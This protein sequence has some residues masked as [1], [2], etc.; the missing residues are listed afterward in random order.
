MTCRAYAAFL[1]AQSLALHPLRAGGTSERRSRDALGVRVSMVAV[2]RHAG[3]RRGRPGAAGL[4]LV[5]PGA[6][7]FFGI[8]GFD[9]VFAVCFGGARPGGCRMRDQPRAQLPVGAG[10]PGR[11][12]QDPRRGDGGRGRRA[13][14]GTRDD[15][16]LR[17]ATSPR[18]GRGQGRQHAAGS[19]RAPAAPGATCGLQPGRVK[20]RL[21]AS[22]WWALP[23]AGGRAVAV[24]DFGAVGAAGGGGAVGVEGDGPAPLVNGDV[25]MEEAVKRTSVH[26]GLAAVG[27]VGHMVDFAG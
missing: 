16:R 6:T 1:V 25:M 20:F 23:G 12:P 13:E 15:R 9:G 2:G 18:G 7:G 19:G 17:V 4:R 8:R 3:G 5:G 10:I 21:G 14:P 27:Q 11:G 26:A 22:A 24:Q